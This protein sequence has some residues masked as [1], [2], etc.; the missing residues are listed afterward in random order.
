MKKII[1]I[2]LIYISL[3]AYSQQKEATV[4]ISC[5]VNPELYLKGNIIT[6]IS[7]KSG[8]YSCVG[9]YMTIYNGSS[10]SFYYRLSKTTKTWSQLKPQ[11]QVI[12]PLSS[13]SGKSNGLSVASLTVRYTE[14]RS[15]NVP[16]KIRTI[17]QMN[18]ATDKVKAKE[19]SGTSKS[20]SKVKPV[21]KKPGQTARVIPPKPRETVKD[22]KKTPATVPDS[23]KKEQKPIALKN[24]ERIP[25]PDPNDTTRSFCYSAS[26]TAYYSFYY[27]KIRDTVLY[28][29]PFP[30]E[31]YED[32]PYG[33]RVLSNA[34]GCL[35]QKITQQ[36]GEARF[37]QYLNDVDYDLMTGF[38]H[39]RN[40]QI[41]SDTIINEYPYT[42][43]HASAEAELQ[44]WLRNEKALNRN[45]VFIKIDFP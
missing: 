15:N 9:R 18:A 11:K 33:Q 20:A 3:T 19:L 13:A 44:T 23:K 2:C 39:I 36:F 25:V 5:Y 21:H 6:F 28:S 27:I 30:V 37:N 43:S 26:D 22:T 41:P 42:R 24:K 29:H 7:D 12:I 10:N 35:S 32:E 40:P 1:A 17:A 16:L 14:E 4:S 8:N 34:W 45:E 38:Q 31:R